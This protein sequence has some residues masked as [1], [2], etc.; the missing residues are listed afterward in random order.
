MRVVKGDLA[1]LD[2]GVAIT[3]GFSFDSGVHL[4]DRARWGLRWSRSCATRPT[5]T[6][7]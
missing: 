3:S 5:S 2:H 1:D 6:R 4:G 7:T